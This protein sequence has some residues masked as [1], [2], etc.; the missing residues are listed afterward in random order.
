MTTPQWTPPKIEEFRISENLPKPVPRA[1]VWPWKANA[2]TWTEIIYSMR[3]VDKFLDDKECP[4]YVLADS[5]PWF[6]AAHKNHR[7]RV[8][9][10]PLYQ[11][12]VLHGTQLADEVLWMNDDI[13]LLQPCR[14]ED[15][16]RETLRFGE[17]SE[18]AALG[19]LSDPQVNPWRKGLARSVLHLKH[20]G[21][22]PVY[23]FSTHTPYI[24]EREKALE[25][26]KIYGLWYKIPLE[27]LYYNHFGTHS[28][29][30]TTEKTR[31]LPAP[32]ALYLNY[33]DSLLTLE[34]RKSL[35]EMFPEMSP[36]QHRA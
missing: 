16:K 20:R 36:W 32:D 18:G 13:C 25:I 6:V 8:L 24:Y 26:F 35:E 30:V 5:I 4:F 19:W 22:N 12:A 14:W 21:I 3:S 34:L 1:V 2:A 28:R 27:T 10:E 31:S 11:T 29:E 15:M 9:E 7:V 17:I 33:V 23:D